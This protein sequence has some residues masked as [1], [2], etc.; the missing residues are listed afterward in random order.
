MK[1]NVFRILFLL[2]IIMS[3]ASTSSAQGIRIWKDG[4]FHEY[5]LNQIDSVSFFMVSDPVAVTGIELNFTELSIMV[6]QSVQLVATVLPAD[7]TEKEV[8]WVTS[9]KSIVTVTPEG[10]VTGVK[11]GSARIVVKDSKGVAPAVTCVVT[12]S[13]YEAVDLGLPSGT[14]W[15]NQNL[16]AKSESDAGFFYGWGELNTRSIYSQQDYT[17]ELPVM[18]SQHD[19]VTQLWGSTWSMPTET[20]MRELITQCTWSW[21]QRG[22]VYGYQ[23]KGP[24]GKTI[25]L[26]STGYRDGD[27]LY[28]PEDMGYYWTGTASRGGSQWA[29][30]LHF[31]KNSHNVFGSSRFS[32]YCIR[33]VTK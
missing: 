26:P 32:G 27:T 29:Y 8:K 21:T 19:V 33:P 13:N 25:F 14:K 12:V 6:G 31:G 20:Q 24:N 5:K 22:S 11:A 10:L 23:V 9:N 30:N 18:D 17:L 1:R 2:L 28:R 7:A 4:E 15:C 16:G 3:W